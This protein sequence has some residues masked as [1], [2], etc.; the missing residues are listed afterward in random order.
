MYYIEAAQ[1]K[2]N[3]SQELTTKVHKISNKTII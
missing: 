2:S 1:F 3:I